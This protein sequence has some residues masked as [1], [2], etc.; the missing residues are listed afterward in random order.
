MYEYTE[1][2]I[3]IAKVICIHTVIIMEDTEYMKQAIHKKNE[4]NIPPVT[5][6]L[7]NNTETNS[8][9]INT[10]LEKVNQ[11]LRKEL[12]NKPKLRKRNN[13]RTTIAK[14]ETDKRKGNRTS[15]ESKQETIRYSQNYIQEYIKTQ[16]YKIMVSIDTEKRAMIDSHLKILNMKKQEYLT[17][18]LKDDYPNFDKDKYKKRYDALYELI[19]NSQPGDEKEKIKQFKKEYFLKEAEEKLGEDPLV[20]DKTIRLYYVHDFINKQ[21][22][23]DIGINEICNVMH[24]TRQWY[25]LKY[26]DC[27]EKRTKHVEGYRFFLSAEQRTI[28]ETQSELRGMSVSDYII[29]LIDKEHKKINN[30]EY[31]EVFEKTLTDIKNP[32]KKTHKEKRQEK[33]EQIFKEAEKDLGADPLT[34]DK[35]VRLYYIDKIMKDPERS[36]G[37]S[38]QLMCEA[39]DVSR[40]WY[41]QVIVKP[42]K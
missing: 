22:R 2:I 27:V 29:F 38:I 19:S 31:K 8:E 26:P 42:N 21:K 35:D 1:D 36:K 32:E 41:Y 9:A 34:L 23:T 13:R 25:Y 24:I 5:S 28:L 3:S 4:D 11:E 16:Y 14:F 18:L 7:K 30:K 20:L 17:A 10:E 33:M 15:A 12:G 39:L 37:K 40:S 6:A